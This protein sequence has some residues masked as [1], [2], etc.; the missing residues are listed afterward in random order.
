[1]SIWGTDYAS[2][3]YLDVQGRYQF[4]QFSIVAGEKE[5]SEEY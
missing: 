4:I 2:G 5:K 3:C 1:L